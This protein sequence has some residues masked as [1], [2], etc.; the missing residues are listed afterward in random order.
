MKIMV[1]FL[2]IVV[3]AFAVFPQTNGGPVTDKIVMDIDRAI[4]DA[5]TKGDVAL[6]DQLVGPDYIEITSQGLVRNKSDIMAI[7]R[8]RASAPKAVAAGPEVS[9]NETKVHVHG[10]VAVFVGLRT[11][12]YQHMEYQVAPGLGQ[13]PPPDFT[14]KERFMKVF[15]RRAGIWQLVASQMT[16]VAA[17]S[18]PPK[19]PPKN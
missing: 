8:A 11:T 15:V 10:S 1:V 2:I 13:L 16:N 19:T 12:K 14:D 6:V 4:V 7:V 9:L 5:I 18:S 3:S 17:A